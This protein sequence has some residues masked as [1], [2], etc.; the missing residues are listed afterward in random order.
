MAESSPLA[1]SP[2]LVSSPKQDT[3]VGERLAPGTA[4]GE[5]LVDRFL[6]AG[7]MGEV[8]AGQQPVIGKKVAIKVLKPEVAAS[9]DG[10]ERFKR[11]ARAVN[12]IDHPNVIDIFSLG[13]LTDGRLYLVMDLVEGKSLRKALADGPLEVDTALDYLEQIA[14][15]LDAAHARGVIHRDLKPDNVMVGTGGKVF[16]LDFGLAKLLSPDDDSVPAASMLTGQGTWLGTPGYMAPEQWSADG[17]GPASDRYSLGV[18]AFELLSG[19]LPFSAPT[20]PQMMEQHFRAKVPA[21]SARGKIKTTA[22][23][24]VVSKAMAKDPLAR[25]PTAREM[26]DALRDV[27]GSKR[28]AKPA[29]KFPMVPAA[30]GAGVLGLSIAAVILVRDKDKPRSSDQPAIQPPTSGMVRVSIASQPTGA[31]IY[32]DGNLVRRTP[33]QLDVHPSTELAFELRKPGYAITRH[34]LTVPPEGTTLPV[35]ELA[36]INGFQGVWQL[37]TKELR[38]FK[39]AGEKIAVS[40][41][42]AVDGPRQFYRH[43][44]LLPSDGGVSFGT[45]E[46]LVDQRAPGDPT[47]HIPHK[48]EY[49]YDP[50]EDVLVVRRERVVVD[51]KDGHCVVMSSAL[52]SAKALVRVDRGATDVRESMAPVGRP[53]FGKDISDQNQNDSGIQKTAPSNN[54]DEKLD[55]GATKTVPQSKKPVPVKQAPPKQELTKAQLGQNEK[56]SL[57]RNSINAPQKSAPQQ[58]NPPP[59]ISKPRGDSQV[60]PQAQ[61]PEPQQKK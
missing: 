44:D 50:Q 5:Y 38:E 34:K 11:E 19:S 21:M 37:P 10:A 46:E 1:H 39:R 48:L 20:L 24:P 59:N 54:V 35:F 6:G 57:D 36:P 17:A 53:D 2:T 49:Q 26:V 9:K 56:G 18:M 15:A 13:R 22:F 60:A 31:E 58:A 30:I 7:A 33:A 43:Y 16:V 45:T 23:D 55:K 14:G 12:Q 51:F 3:A 4:V 29:G 41:L 28:A 32:Q 42:E 27:S 40:K 47:C 8:Y 52:D 61:F 25:F